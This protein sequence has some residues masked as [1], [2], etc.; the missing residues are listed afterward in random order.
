[1]KEAT[2][3]PIFLSGLP[4]RRLASI[5]SSEIPLVSGTK[6]RKKRTKSA[7]K[8]ERRSFL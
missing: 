4:E 1:M 5:F 2:Q 6:K 8:M 3:R 7:L